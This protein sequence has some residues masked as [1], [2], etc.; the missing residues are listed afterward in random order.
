M[1]E[2][3]AG[4]LVLAFVI[5][6]IEMTEVVALVFALRGETGSVAVGAWGAIAGVAVVALAALGTGTALTQVPR[7]WLLIG[8]AITLG[9]FGVFLFRSTRR[10]FHRAWFPSPASPGHDTGARALQFSG[11]MTIGVVEAME[12]VVVLIPLAAAGSGASALVGAAAGGLLLVALAVAMHERIRRIKVPW[13]KLGATALLFSYAMF[14]V[15]EAFNFPW[16]YGDLS[17]LP[18]F[19]VYILLLSEEHRLARAQGNRAHRDQS[20]RPPG[21][22]EPRCA[23]ARAPPP[24][25]RRRTRRRK[26]RR[27]P[28]PGGAEVTGGA[29]RS[30][31]GRPRERRK[32][33]RSR[34]GLARPARAAYWRAR[35]AIWFEPLVA[36]AI[37]ALLVVGLWAY[38]QNWPPIYVVESSSMQH[39]VDDHLGLINTG[40]LVLAQK[41][42]PATVIPYVIGMQT[43]YVTYGEYGDVLLYHPNGD[44]SVTPI[45][46]RAIVYLVH[47]SD[48][49]WS[50]PALSGLACS[51]SSHPYYRISTTSDGCGSNHVTGTLTLYGIGWQN[52]SIPIPLAT[53]G[54]SSGFV[55]MGDNN[56]LSGTPG[57]GR[58]TSRSPSAPWSR[59][60]GS[61]GWRAA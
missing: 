5:T 13:L 1:V 50:Y 61:W 6:V 60:A 20:L 8:A 25:T 30:G 54:Q 10:A 35:D 28:A 46:H 23:P 19:V 47:N 4:V 59:K 26:R 53:L 16:P 21:R 33:S 32:T 38:A 42:D 44:S 2:F 40:D 22:L 36:L 45:I 17:L 58:S 12:V 39:G 3:V 31:P 27:L 51:S 34:E 15:G 14:F 24:R 57:R 43:G 55:T 9:A 18:L 37:V 52:A 11:G 29:G 56:Y 7:E 41:V 49:T 48:G